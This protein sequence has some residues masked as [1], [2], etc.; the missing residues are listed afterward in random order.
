MEPS[1]DQKAVLRMLRKNRSVRDYGMLYT[2]TTGRGSG[3]LAYIYPMDALIKYKDKFWEYHRFQTP[4][5]IP[6]GLGRKGLEQYA[7]F[8]ANREPENEIR[9]VLS[10][11]AWKRYSVSRHCRERYRERF[12]GSRDNLICCRRIGV[13]AT[14]AR[15]CHIPEQYRLVRAIKY[16]KAALHLKYDPMNIIF[17]IT[18]NTIVTCFEDAIEDT[19]DDT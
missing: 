16:G 12:G 1:E 11:K 9:K 17:A 7:L 4:S 14:L 19:S 2:K 5:G 18:D 6:E 10:A 13:L 3:E 15:R 8:I